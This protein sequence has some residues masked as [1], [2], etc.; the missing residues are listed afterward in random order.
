MGEGRSPLDEAPVHLRAFEGSVLCSRAPGQGS[1]GVLA[2]P[3]RP[4]HLPYLVC[5]GSRTDA[6]C[7][8]VRIF[9]V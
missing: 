4:E 8:A 2:S 5:P 6:H 3:L 7:L 1:E 9:A